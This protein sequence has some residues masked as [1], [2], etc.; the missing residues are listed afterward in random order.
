MPVDSSISTVPPNVWP[1]SSAKL[2]FVPLIPST[3]VM[4][5]SSFGRN[6]AT[7]R[8]DGVQAVEDR[9]VVDLSGRLG[10]FEFVIAWIEVLELV[11][12][13]GSGGGRA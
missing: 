1:T 11:R 10:F 13:I 2:L 5:S 7:L 9:E 3:K 12:A 6:G 4:V 8:T